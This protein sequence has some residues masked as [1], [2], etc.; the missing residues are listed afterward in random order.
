[1]DS[2]YVHFAQWKHLVMEQKQDSEACDLILVEIKIASPSAVALSFW[3]I[4]W[5]A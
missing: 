3:V 2:L 4:V 1:M 5:S